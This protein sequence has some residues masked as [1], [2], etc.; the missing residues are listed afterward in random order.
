MTRENVTADAWIERSKVKG[1]CEVLVDKNLEPTDDLKEGRWGRKFPYYPVV[2]ARVLASD[3]K[4]Y[5]AR[6]ISS[7]QTL[8]SFKCSITYR[9]GQKACS[10]SGTGKIVDGIVKF[11]A[12][13]DGK[14]AH[15]LPPGLSRVT[16][17]REPED[18]LPKTL[19]EPEPRRVVKLDLASL[20]EPCPQYSLPED[21]T[22]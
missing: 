9:E 6:S 22:R 7:E 1:E 8:T 5:S 19:V 15:Y 10:I 2:A 3:N 20:A 12:N 13:P 18:E 14:N 16:L 21:L 17:W 11:E 4:T